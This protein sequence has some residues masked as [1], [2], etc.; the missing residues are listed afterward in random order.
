[1]EIAVFLHF[2]FQAR[3]FD[4][5]LN[6]LYPVTRVLEKYHD[7]M[8]IYKK[9]PQPCSIRYLSAGLIEL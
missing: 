4:I 2:R 9:F 6:L 3:W 8:T 1:M 5:L 7:L